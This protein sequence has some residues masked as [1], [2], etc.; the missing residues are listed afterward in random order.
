MLNNEL[1][2]QAVEV[3]GRVLSESAFIFT[4]PIEE[5]KKPD[6][7]EWDVKGV[8]LSFSGHCNGRLSMWAGN[9]FLR[10]AAANMLGLDEDSDSVREKIIDA[11]KEI[12]NIIVGNLLTE[13]YGT[14]PI[15]DLSIPE[16]LSNESVKIDYDPEKAIWLEAEGNPVLFI[17]DIE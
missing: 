3:I 10:C 11:L 1:I 4:D 8:S 7:N 17:V 12:L 13:V 9:E 15:F 14:E 5:D 6:V 2:E 16:K